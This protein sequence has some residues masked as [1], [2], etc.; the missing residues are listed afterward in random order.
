MAGIAHILLAL[1]VAGLSAGTASADRFRVDGDTL[2][3]DTETG[4]DTRGIHQDD[5]EG[6]IAALRANDSVTTVR[7]HSTGG[8]YYSAFD[9]AKV[10]IDFELNT[11]IVDECASA[12]AYVFLGGVRRTMWR[13]AQLGFHRT[14]WNAESVEAYY[15]DRRDDWG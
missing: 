10:I 1:A 9:M 8:G 5:V 15:N 13:G 4:E 14:Y 7:L 3:F 2:V 11:E 6:L 12:C